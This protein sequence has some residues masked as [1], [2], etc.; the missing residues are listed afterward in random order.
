MPVYLTAQDEESSKVPKDEHI[1]DALV[2]QNRQHLTSTASSLNSGV[3]FTD[4]ATR[5]QDV[6][7][8]QVEGQSIISTHS[9]STLLTHIDMTITRPHR[10]VLTG[11]SAI[12]RPRVLRFMQLPIEIRQMIWRYAMLA[13]PYPTRFHHQPVYYLQFPLEVRNYVRRDTIGADPRNPSFL[14]T[15]CRV[16]QAT[17]RETI[18]VFLQGTTFRTNSIQQNHFMHAFLSHAPNGFA[19][20]R[21]LAFAF[22]DCFPPGFDQNADLELAV[23][24]TGL[25]EIRLSFHDNKLVHWVAPHDTAGLQ[26]PR[27]ASEMWDYY[28][29]DRLFEG[30]NRLRK[31]VL[32]HRGWGVAPAG[33][34]LLNF[35][36]LI[37][38]KFLEERSRVVD[39]EVI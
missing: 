14:P 27:P 19:S 37:E 11:W 22:F 30:G 17:Y 29:M 28:K 21:T 1:S 35:A 32:I 16:S 34:A 33:Q 25:Q 8:K 31:V 36:A 5:A 6:L 13:Q 10:V 3:V 23:R 39:T 15:V 7:S 20:V 24:C 9:K 26:E 38:H 18:E 12:V 2:E 4:K